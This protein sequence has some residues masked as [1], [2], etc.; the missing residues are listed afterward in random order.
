MV[1]I[2]PL[3]PQIRTTYSYEKR[4]QLH[5]Y[6][7]LA[8]SVEINH[9]SVSA[10]PADCEFRHQIPKMTPAP[11]D[12]G[13]MQAVVFHGPYKVAVE[14]RPI[15]KVQD[16]EDVIV[17]VGYTALCGSELHMFRGVEPAGKDFIM[18]H[19]FVGT[20]VEM[21]SAVKTLQKGDRV[22][23]AF[24]TSCGECFYCK[25]GWSSRCDKNGLFGCDSLDGG[26]AEYARIPNAEGS[27]MKAPEGVDEKYLV[28]MGDI[29]PTGWFAANNAFKNSTPQQIAEQTVVLIGCGPVG[30][31]AL[32]NAL[33]YKPKH[34]LA[35]DSVPSRLELAKSLGAEPWNFQLDRAGLDKRVQ[36]LTNGRG[37]D[38]VIEVVGLSPAL[39]TGFELLRPWGTISS[40]GV[41]NGEIPWDGN[42]AYSKNLTVQMGRCPVR[43]VAPRALEVLKR[44]QHKLGFMTDK[45]M[46]LSQA[47]EGY[48][49]FEAH[50]QNTTTP[51]S[52]TLS[53][54]HLPHLRPF[55]SSSPLLL[56]LFSLSPIDC[57]SCSP[58]SPPLLIRDSAAFPSHPFLHFLSPSSSLPS[59]DRTVFKK[60][61]IPPFT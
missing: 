37:A 61:S 13:M 1:A 6:P 34:I 47:V 55:S 57:F 44:N 49:L 2:I 27:V 31:C 20:I 28:L 41:H 3:Y 24:T 39:R 35:V 48:K 23:T 7:I 16:P 25:Q 51:T 21:G 33:E 8:F 19:E 60:P 58:S 56:L 32:I 36:E 9:C 59:R 10:P 15:P 52:S 11:S 26:Q 53:H 4:S 45:I 46:P 18:G 22:V 5:L 14:Q 40:V 17:K 42:D 43:S 38:A 12:S 29:F 30:L 54:L 50:Q